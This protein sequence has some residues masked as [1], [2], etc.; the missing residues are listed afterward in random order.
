MLGMPA[1]QIKGA[2]EGAMVVLPK[3]VGG[4]CNAM[5]CNA[6]QCS[7]RMVVDA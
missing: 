4:W 3:L 5:Q 7:V 1:L 6:M 2:K